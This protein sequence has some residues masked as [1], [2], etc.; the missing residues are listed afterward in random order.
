RA[1]GR[2]ARPSETSPEYGFGSARRPPISI[3]E[4]GASQHATNCRTSLEAAREA[5]TLD[6]AD[7]EVWVVN[8]ESVVKLG[9]KAGE[10]DCLVD[11]GPKG[12]GTGDDVCVAAP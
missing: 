1:R 9:L 3:A 2:G 5:K 7:D 11:K 6:A 10:V 8:D 4:G 12:G